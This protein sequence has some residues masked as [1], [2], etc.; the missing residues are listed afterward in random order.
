M[1]TIE[2]PPA[3]RISRAASVEQKNVPF[4]FVSITRSQ[5][6]SLGIGEVDPAG[7]AGAVDEHVEPV[8]AART[9]SRIC[10]TSETS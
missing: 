1:F 8:E 5:V 7:D 9:S 4:R 10:A 2:P 3:A 6:S